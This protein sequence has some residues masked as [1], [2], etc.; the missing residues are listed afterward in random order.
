MVDMSQYVSFGVG[1][2][3]RAFH[4]RT[5]GV[6]HTGVIVKLGRVYAHVDFGPLRGGVCRV[7]PSDILEVVS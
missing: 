4:P 3:V 6:V 5:V 7:L 1:D 2:T